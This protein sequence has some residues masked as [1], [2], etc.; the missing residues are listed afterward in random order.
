MTDPETV[1]CRPDGSS[2]K[3]VEIFAY[4]VDL[5]VDSFRNWPIGRRDSITSGGGVRRFL[6]SKKLKFSGREWKR[7]YANSF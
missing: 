5:D 6:I 2:E 1:S 4:A 3:L 7:I